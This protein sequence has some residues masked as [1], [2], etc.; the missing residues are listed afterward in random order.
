MPK[1][2]PKYGLKAAGQAHVYII[3][4]ILSVRDMVP[5]SKRRYREVTT[6][7]RRAECL[8]NRGCSPTSRLACWPTL[9]C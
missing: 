5:E 2:V 1:K 7:G 3:A 6:E 4:H 8:R 9:S